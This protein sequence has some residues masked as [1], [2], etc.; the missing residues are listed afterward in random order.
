VVRGGA[1]GDF[2]LTLPVLAAL[3][4]HFPATH[5][6]IVGYPRYA[7]LASVARLADDVRSIESRGLARFFAQRGVL[8]P[9][10][11]A[12]FE[13]FHLIVSYLYDPD[14]L[15]QGN[16]K[17][18][19]KA[20]FVQGPHRP[21]EDAGLHAT[22]ALLQPLQRL[23]IFDADPVPK[24]RMPFPK[25]NAL[26][27]GRWMAIHPGSGSEKKNWPEPCWAELLRRLGKVADVRTLLVGG[28]AEGGRLERLAENLPADRV[29]I[30][31]SLPLATLADWMSGCECFVG[32]DSGVSHLAAAI[33]LRGLLLWGP[34]DPCVWRPRSPVMELL[35]SD[36]GI[37]NIP[38]ESTLQAL[39]SL[40]G[41]GNA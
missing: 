19:S 32:H 34:T 16:I 24:L 15:F 31:R 33:G 40:L 10:W 26:G 37:Q 27:A 41:S 22:D 38:V 21:A 7:E 14:E 11:A 28:E 23:A 4:A 12:Y 39:C 6:E 8:D 13:S 17:R 29:K 20:Q 35:S 25:E 2:I 3:R 1:L 36:Q 9:D 18:C 30:A 5:L